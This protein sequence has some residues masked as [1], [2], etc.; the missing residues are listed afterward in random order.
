[1]AG[2]IPGFSTSVNSSILPSSVCSFLL[3]DCLAICACVCVCVRTPVSVTENI[4]HMPL[5]MHGEV[6]GPRGGAGSLLPLWYQALF[7][8]RCP[9]DRAHIWSLAIFKVKLTFS[10]WFCRCSFLFLFHLFWYKVSLCSPVWFNTCYCRWVWL[11]TFDPASFSQV[12][13]LITSVCLTLGFSL[14]L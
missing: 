14:L 7:L 8:L 5:C 12:L 10:H 2:F 3:P 13:T 11:Q 9:A 6:R 1:M 4:H